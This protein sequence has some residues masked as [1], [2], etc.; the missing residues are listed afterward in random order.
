ML[1]TYPEEWVLTTGTALLEGL[2]SSMG[3]LLFPSHYQ[4]EVTFC[5]FTENSLEV[6]EDWVSLWLDFQGFFFASNGIHTQPPA[7]CQNHHI[8]VSAGLVWLSWLLTKKCVSTVAFR[9]WFSHFSQ[10][11]YFFQTQFTNGSPQNY[12]V[13][14]FSC[15]CVGGGRGVRVCVPMMYCACMFD[16]FFCYCFVRHYPCLCMCLTI[17]D[18]TDIYGM[19]FGFLFLLQKL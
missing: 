2:W 18:I 7:S 9:N 12:I 17:S 1:V 5:A 19:P 11:L 4:E 15:E 8:H 3:S 13:R 16:L 14:L 10:F 6:L